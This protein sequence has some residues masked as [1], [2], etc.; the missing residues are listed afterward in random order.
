MAQVGESVNKNSRGVL[1]N[2]EARQ[3][4]RKSPEKYLN[5]D[6][7]QEIRELFESV[8]VANKWRIVQ[9]NFLRGVAFGL[10][11]FIGGTIVVALVV[12]IL[13]HTVDL[14]PWARDFTERLIDSIQ[15]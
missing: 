15:K 6:K 2:S 14:F 13:A 10:G 5:D 3:N 9:M 12:W 4:S 11:T 8:Y 1:R 7:R